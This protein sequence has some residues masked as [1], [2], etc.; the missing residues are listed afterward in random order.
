MWTAVMC[1]FQ[2]KVLRVSHYKNGNILDKSSSFSLDL[3]MRGMDLLRNCTRYYH[4]VREK[5][6]FVILSHWKLMLFCLLLQQDLALLIDTNKYPIL[7]NYINGK[8]HFSVMSKS[9]KK[10]WMHIYTAWIHRANVWTK[11]KQL[12]VIP[13]NYMPFLH[14]KL[15][16]LIYNFLEQLW[17]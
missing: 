1:Q 3:R 9:L 13:G 2:A 5:W 12:L 16:E 17:K 6:I 10:L 8:W 14:E 15:T 7:I 11:W 4:K